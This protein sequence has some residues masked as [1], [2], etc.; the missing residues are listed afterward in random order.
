MAWDFGFA[1]WI[2]KKAAQ[3]TNSVVSIGGILA[4]IIRRPTDGHL[5]I[6]YTPTTGS[7]IIFDAGLVP[8][9][10]S[11]TAAAIQPADGH[12]ILTFDDATTLDVGRVVGYDGADG[13]DGTDGRE[14]ELDVAGT[15][16]RFRYAGM[17]AWTNLFD[18]S[19]IDGGTGTVKSVNAIS[20]DTDGD[21]E[22]NAEDVPFESAL[23]APTQPTDPVPLTSVEVRSALD[24]LTERNQAVNNKAD[25]IESDLQ[26]TNDNLVQ[27]DQILNDVTHFLFGD[28]TPIT[29]NFMGYITPNVPA[30]FP[31]QLDPT[32]TPQAGE[33]NWRLLP[34]NI[35]PTNFPLSVEQ[36]RLFIRTGATWI[37]QPPTTG[38]TYTPAVGDMWKM[39]NTAQ[40]RFINNWWNGTQFVEGE[41]PVEVAGWVKLIETALT[42][43]Y[44]K[45][46][47]ADTTGTL[48]NLIIGKR[49]PLTGENTTE[50][51]QLP[52][53]SNLTDLI[54][55]QAN[56]GNKLVDFN[57]MESS[58]QSALTSIPAGLMPPVEIDLEST[59]PPEAGL[60][61]ADVGTFY[62]IQDMDV[63]MAGRTGK[64]WANHKDGNPNNPVVWYRVYDQ[65]YSADG[66]TITLTSTG[67]LQVAQALIQRIQDNES[68]IEV[69]ETAVLNLE[70]EAHTHANK[71]L[72]DTIDQPML[73][74]MAQ[75]LVNP[76]DTSPYSSMLEMVNG[77][78]GGA[79][80]LRGSAPRYFAVAGSVLNAWDDSPPTTLSTGMVFVEIKATSSFA[81]STEVVITELTS[82]TS[83][84]FRRCCSATAWNIG[85]NT[86]ASREWVQP[87]LDAK[88]NMGATLLANGTD[89]ATLTGNGFYRINSGSDMNT[90]TNQP[91]LATTGGILRTY[92]NGTN[93][94]QFF[95]GHSGDIH[96]HNVGTPWVTQATQ[97]WAMPRN[98]TMLTAG[99]DL[100]TAN[101]AV[102][103]YGL[104][105][106]DLPT[107]QN[108]PTGFP[109]NSNA[110]M[111]VERVSSPG[112]QKQTLTTTPGGGVT[113]RVWVRNSNFSGDVWT[114][115]VELDIIKA[116]NDRNNP[117]SWQQNVEIDFGDGT[118]G[119]RHTGNITIGANTTHQINSQTPSMSNVIDSGG[120]FGENTQYRRFGFGHYVDANTFSN[121][122]S[123]SPDYMIYT[124]ASVVRTS[125][126]YDIWVRY[127]KN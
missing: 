82:T 54:P 116:V 118:F 21:V 65:Y 68:A 35:P 55:T 40:N 29:P 64:A 60:T 32:L 73:N 120:W 6:T 103:F 122:I 74:R 104:A 58:I 49:D 23:P 86:Y 124:R 108:L 43:S 34:A 46:V 90:M 110:L 75:A 126:P 36:Y 53:P 96:L 52:L 121:V 89:W 105:S 79:S 5:I 31:E 30:L 47:E 125:S 99:T 71:T 44:L 111:L 14:I 8:A 59:L 109:T 63:S 117:N 15:M 84:Q 10:K 61:D 102:G 88:M 16:L 78:S 9:G 91:P 107:I 72:I 101:L 80:G 38:I 77:V 85:W 83:R 2:R 7:S 95:L 41:T 50:I 112:N 1:A 42:G 123:Q 98:P 28:A 62:I 94:V 45:S 115:W 37:Q 3:Y 76:L 81:T 27:T 70:S 87:L 114:A 11:I 92:A 33:N 51:I 93:T 39:W 17:T 12:L 19:T 18:F 4:S 66:T 56:A 20:P 100:N 25:T 113:T 69:L 97:D 13:Q 26:T 106:A 22:L 48:V 24:E 127:R 67:Q 57:L 119:W